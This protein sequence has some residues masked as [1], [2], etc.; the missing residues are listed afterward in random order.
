MVLLS[1]LGVAR[2]KEARVKGTFLAGSNLS[3][4]PARVETQLVTPAR[5]RAPSVALPPVAPRVIPRPEAEYVF[6]G[7]SETY[8]PTVAF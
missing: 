1:L 2:W 4:T 6:T 8:D 7:A 5:N 3:S